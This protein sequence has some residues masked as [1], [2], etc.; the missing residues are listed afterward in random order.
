MVYA[1]LFHG[2]I[3]FDCLQLFNANSNRHAYICEWKLCEVVD[4]IASAD[5]YMETKVMLFIRVY[6]VWGKTKTTAWGKIPIT[7]ICA[8][9]IVRSPISS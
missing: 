9:F 7:F 3:A 5:S 6:A 8:P 4:S 1:L 2:P